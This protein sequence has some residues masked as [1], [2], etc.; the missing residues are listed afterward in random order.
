MSNHEAG[1]YDRADLDKS[2]DTFNSDGAALK[3]G[4]HGQK[5]SG[6]RAELLSRIASW[7]GDI[8]NR[9]GGW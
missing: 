7:L 2:L 1:P 5:G 9:S 6:G 4:F 3:A 8:Q